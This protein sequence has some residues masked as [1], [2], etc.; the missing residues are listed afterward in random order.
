MPPTPPMIF[1]NKTCHCLPPTLHLSSLWWGWTHICSPVP[2]PL[3]SVC[4]F[5]RSLK[6]TRES[7]H[8]EKAMW[9]HS[10]HLFLRPDRKSKMERDR[11][12][13]SEGKE[14][15]NASIF[16]Y[17]YTPWAKAEKAHLLLQAAF[18]ES[19]SDMVSCFTQMHPS[20]TALFPT[21]E[22]S[23]TISMSLGQHSYS[24][25]CFESPLL[26]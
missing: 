19:M 11:E 16:H 7:V 20:V 17:F 10:S 8:L 15:I 26:P 12:T 25:V 14:V 6:N 9:Q 4:S 23:S 22:S 24:R 18:S 2:L 13:E 5:S 3:C 1:Q 21:H